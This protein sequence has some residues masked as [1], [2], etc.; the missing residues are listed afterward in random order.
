[1]NP[2]IARSCFLLGH[3]WSNLN[4]ISG[5]L[6]CSP[7]FPV[8]SFFVVCLLIIS[9]NLR[10]TQSFDKDIAPNNLIFDFTQML[11]SFHVVIR[12][13]TAATVLGS[14]SIPDLSTLIIELRYLNWFHTFS[15][16]PPNVILFESLFLI[17]SHNFL[18]TC[19]YLEDVSSDF[20][21]RLTSSLLATLSLS[22]T[23]RSFVGLYAPT[24]TVQWCFSGQ[25]IMM[26]PRKI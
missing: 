5:G 11:L 24:L 6:F 13:T 3:L 18:S 26:L 19:F 23:K 21:T 2:F 25:S 15:L 7:S 1:M 16:W 20:Y 4:R 14:I 8:L 9:K 22:I 12:F 10:S 17:I